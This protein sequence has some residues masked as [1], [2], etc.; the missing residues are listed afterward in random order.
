MTAMEQKDLSSVGKNLFNCIEFDQN[1]QLIFEI[2]KHFIGLLFIYFLGGLITTLFFGLTIFGFSLHGDSLGIGV[3]I[4]SFKAVAMLIGFILT[5]ISLIGTTIA[6]HLY[7]NNVII[8]TS[9]KI[10]Q[11]LYP[12]IFN[13][14]ISQLGLG[15]VQDVTVNQV[16]IL[17]QMFNYGTIVIETSG[18]QDNYIFS[19]APNPYESSKAI[20]GAHERN[21]QTYGN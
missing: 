5:V 16:G 11:F 17:P 3:D 10:A 20:V 19:Y 21:V 15:H 18:E 12:T 9:E 14:K 8:V 6:A 13:R 4:E 7:R 2:R 1:E